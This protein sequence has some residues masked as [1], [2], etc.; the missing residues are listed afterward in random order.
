MV[1]IFYWINIF[2]RSVESKSFIWKK[3]FLVSRCLGIKYVFV[4]LK[5]YIKFN[6]IVEIKI[7]LVVSIEW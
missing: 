3:I 2:F 5:G 4:R 7:K 6:V 1:Y